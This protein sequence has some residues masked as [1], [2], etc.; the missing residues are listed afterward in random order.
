MTVYFLT[1]KLGSG[2]SLM[3]VSK[4]REYLEA[5]RRVATNL[6][7]Y[8]DAMFTNNK[9]SIVRLPDKPRI[10]D[11]KAL[12]SGYES[13]DPR[14][15][16][17]SKYGLIVLDEC[18]TWLNSRE[19]NDKGRRA[20]ID[21][22]LHARKH[23][24]DV[25]FLI[26]DIEACDGQIVR[27]LCEHLVICRR[28]DRYRVFKVRLPRFHIATVYYGTTANKGNFVERWVYRG[29]EL[30]AAYDTRQCFSDGLEFHGNDLVDMRAMYS[31]LSAYHVKGRYITS[32]A[33]S[34]SFGQR[35]ARFAF[36][37]VWGPYLL[38][39]SL[40]DSERFKRQYLQQRQRDSVLIADRQITFE[41]E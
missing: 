35:L 7:I 3:S 5:G 13:D 24:W 16:T 28:M 18:G 37:A 8:L 11:M 10:E 22:F 14:D 30:Y 33:A 15:N 34:V 27:A 32:P 2:K 29:T 12:G 40:F 1:G 25:I 41:R 17:E 38:W 39:L 19:W 36:W 6:D 9:S 31:V 23:R 21:W 4:I 20:L 26:Q